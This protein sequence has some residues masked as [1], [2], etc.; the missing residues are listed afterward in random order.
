MKKKIKKNSLF[1]TYTL[2]HSE[3]LSLHFTNSRSERTHGAVGRESPAY[4][5]NTGSFPVQGTEL[6][7]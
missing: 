6:V 5:T 1:V 2:K 3:I 4:F 7:T